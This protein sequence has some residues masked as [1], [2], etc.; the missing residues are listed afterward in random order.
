MYVVYSPIVFSHYITE[1]DC[2]VQCLVQ[3][4]YPTNH[5]RRSPCPYTARVKGPCCHANSSVWE[6]DFPDSKP[7][8][9]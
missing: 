1:H 5:Q 9:S 6:Q 7:M 4:E 3:I 2:A 8:Y